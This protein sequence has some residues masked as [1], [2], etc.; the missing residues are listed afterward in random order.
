[1]VEFAFV[2]VLLMLLLFGI[3]NFGV[4]LSVKNQV[5]QAANEGARSGVSVFAR[6]GLAYAEVNGTVPATAKI[7]AE[8][9]ALDRMRERLSNLEGDAGG[10]IQTRCSQP[11]QCPTIA[12][13]P[14]ITYLARVHDCI[15]TDEALLTD[16]NTA[17]DTPDT[18]DCL[19]TKITYNHDRYP[20]LP[21]IPLLAAAI[22]ENVIDRADV[23]L[24]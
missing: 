5:T 12:G 8:Q 21:R 15:I 24:T 6:N 7:L 1:M 20:V 13:D 4:L 11:A 10:T 2:G 3:V 14:S 23:A 17:V 22:P 16:F 18:N 9:A 19:F